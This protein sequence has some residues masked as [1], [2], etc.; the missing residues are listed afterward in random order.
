[1]WAWLD[2]S[3][4]LTKCNAILIQSTSRFFGTDLFTNLAP[5]T[6]TAGANYIMCACTQSREKICGKC[7]KLQFGSLV[8]WF[9]TVHEGNSILIIK[10]EYFADQRQQMAMNSG[11]K[12]HFS[13][14][15][16]RQMARIWLSLENRIFRVVALT[17]LAS[18]HDFL[19]ENKLS[20]S[21]SSPK[22]HD[23]CLE[24]I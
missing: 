5:H 12:T 6:H 16:A 2:Y 1:M 4:A 13:S 23:L 17:S 20:L 15:V 22:G 9:A 24:L 14:C 18:D 21:C 19:S 11:Q 8:V 7:S 3:I 10:S